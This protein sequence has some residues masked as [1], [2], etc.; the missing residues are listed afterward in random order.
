MI[1]TPLAVLVNRMQSGLGA[2]DF[3]TI[4]G[5]VSKMAAFEQVLPR[6]TVYY[7]TDYLYKVVRFNRKNSGVALRELKE[8]PSERFQSSYSRSRS[9][10]LQYALCNQWDH[11]ITITVDKRLHDRYQLMPIYETI[12]AF[13]KFY[14]STFSGAF[15]FLLVPEYHDDGAWHFHGLVRGVLPKHLSPFIPGRHPKKLIRK[16][17]VN[18]GMLASVS[19]FVSLSE[20]KNPTGAAFYVTKYI[21]KQHA[22]DAFYDHLYFHSRGLSTAKAVA[23]C[24]IDNHVLDQCLTFESPFCSTGW[25]KSAD[26]DFTFPYSISGCQPR[27]E[28]ELFPSDDVGLETVQLPS[29][30]DFQPVQLTLEEWLHPEL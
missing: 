13:F 3:L 11:F 20:I 7:F 10:V 2:L 25:F 17:Y 14:R 9:M 21:T 16:G 29:Q 27:E 28:G 18:W 19:G 22:N 5:D 12:Y 8:E 24:Y 1:G 6:Y 15:R 30:E 4:S 23:D 26:G